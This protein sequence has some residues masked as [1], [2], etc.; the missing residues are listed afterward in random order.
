MSAFT[1]AFGMTLMHFLWQG[2]LIGCATAVVLTLLRNSRAEY[3]Y[4]AACC[5][6]LACLCW[7]ALEL[8]QRLTGDG[9]TSSAS[10][11][12][13]QL[14]IYGFGPEQGWFNL[15]DSLRSI[16][17]LWALCAAVL[18]LRM[19]AGLRWIA[20]I[21]RQ[22]DTHP[23]QQ[24]WEAEL[25]RL[26]QAFGIARAVRLRVTATL[27]SPVT[28]G[29]WRPVVVMP[30]ALL[31]GMQPDLLHALLAHE[32][33]HI[34]RHDYLVN[35]LQNLIETLLFYH[36]A[37]WWISRRIRVERELIADRLAAQHLGEPRRLA[38]ALS[39]LEKLRFSGQQLALAAN[40][41]HLLLRIQHLLR[42]S[43][44]SLN[45]KAALAMLAVATVCLSIYAQ[46]TA[47]DKRTTV[48]R[49]AVIDF[50]TCTKPAWPQ[51]AIAA[52]RTG[53]VQLAFQVGEDGRVNNSRIERTSGH[54]DLDEA[55]RSGIG[56]C[57]F[58]PATKAGKPFATWQK[59]QYVWTLE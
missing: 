34:K 5:A 30:A 29:W 58:K 35:L 27:A 20:R 53:R 8:W 4:L 46:A 11:H 7:P 56:K 14:G 54:A 36:P 43:P 15:R 51:G 32:M 13:F 47:A 57:Q 3:R 48:T 22:R 28:A 40:G 42:P 6:L 39:E 41:G 38:L 19:L 33:A 59:V 49:A 16:V 12:G 18:A 45:W 50:N 37:V 21:S 1:F 25:A 52:N 44:Q 23:H 10:I 9:A 2:L 31:T 24:R 17:S 26:A 55:A